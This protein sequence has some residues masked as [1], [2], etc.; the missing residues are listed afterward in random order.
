MI[1]T[2]IATIFLGLFL[3]VFQVT[4]ETVTTTIIGGLVSYGLTNIFK[5]WTGAMRFL[6]VALTYVIC[7]IVAIVSTIGVMY[8]NGEAVTSNAVIQQSF[9][10]F[11]LA[12]F[13]YRLIPT[14]SDE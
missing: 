10:I 12:T 4:A 8:Y 3:F 5:S 1:L 13:A 11:T 7:L 6:A 14:K 2:L 9:A